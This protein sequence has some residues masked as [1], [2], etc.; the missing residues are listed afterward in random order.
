MTSSQCDG[1]TLREETWTVSPH[2]SWVVDRMKTILVH[3]STGKVSI[4]QGIQAAVWSWLNLGYPYPILLEFIACLS[5]VSPSV[6]Q[7][8][9]DQMLIEWQGLGFVDRKALQND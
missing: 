8:E 6:A 2:I 9:L 4:L 1:I 7:V 5:K 3:E